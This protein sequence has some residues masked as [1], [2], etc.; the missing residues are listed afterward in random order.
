MAGSQQAHEV[1]LGLVR[2]LGV[3]RLPGLP[4]MS[5]EDERHVRRGVLELGI[6]RGG[7]A[8]RAR[9]ARQ[10]RCRDHHAEREGAS[11]GDREAL[12]HPHLSHGQ[13]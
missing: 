10:G 12:R 4:R 5:A 1:S 3:L 9:R 2:Q 6:G 8:R 11:C 13:S 7:R